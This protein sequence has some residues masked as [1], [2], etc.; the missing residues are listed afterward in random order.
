MVSRVRLCFSV[1][2]VGVIDVF[3]VMVLPLLINVILFIIGISLST[4][5]L[6]LGK[7]SIL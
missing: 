3:H 5:D 1:L 6:L 2:K 4:S 7:C